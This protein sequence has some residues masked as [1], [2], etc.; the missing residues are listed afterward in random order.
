MRVNNQTSDP[1][2][3]EQNGS[4]GT[5]ENGSRCPQTG[6]VAKKDS[7]TLPY[8]CPNPPYALTLRI[9]SEPPVE[10]RISGITDPD[11]TVTLAN[12]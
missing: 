1:V 6:Q 11:L 10:V 8:L 7:K 12:Q 3:Y 9:Q 5:E 2:D 4:G